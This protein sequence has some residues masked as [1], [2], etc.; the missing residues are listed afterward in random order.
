[1]HGACAQHTPTS[2]SSRLGSRT[3]LAGAHHLHLGLSLG[4][5]QVQRTRWERVKLGQTVAVVRAHA[6][7]TA[8][9]KV[10]SCWLVLLLVFLL[11]KG[12]PAQRAGGPQA[13]SHL[14][15]QLLMRLPLLLPGPVLLL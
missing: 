7:S 3:A 8:V 5:Q 11:E 1:M 14:P 10:Q 4:L 15:M 12:V 6:A 2:S 9:G 13:C